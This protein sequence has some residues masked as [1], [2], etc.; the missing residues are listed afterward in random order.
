[1]STFGL[2][3]IPDYENEFWYV[4]GL[5]Y[6]KPLIFVLG[7]YFNTYG[8]TLMLCSLAIGCAAAMHVYKFLDSRV[9]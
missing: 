4:S 2:G 1:M 3:K 5:I 7:A 8:F 6:M 9:A